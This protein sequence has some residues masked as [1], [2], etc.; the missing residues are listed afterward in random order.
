MD[1][2]KIKAA[3]ECLLFVSGDPVSLKE[4][5][6]ALEVDQATLKKIINQLTDDFDDEARGIK[7]VEINGSYQLCSRSEL[8]EYVEKLLK[9]K[10][11]TGL[12]QASLETL[13]IIAYKQPITKSSIDSVRGVKSDACITRLVEK[14]MIKEIGRM[15]GPGRPI[16]YGTTDTFLRLFGLKSIGELPPLNDMD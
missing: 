5:S 8:Y 16:L 6:S 13:S 1:I 10:A 14:D 11:K 9:P 15:E 12:S 7:I 4:L 2:K 3:V